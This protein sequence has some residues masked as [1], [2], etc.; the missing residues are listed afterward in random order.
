MEPMGVHLTPEEV[1]VAED[2]VEALLNLNYLIGEDAANP[3][4]IREYTQI[5]DGRLKAMIE[6]LGSAK[7]WNAAEH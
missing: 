2:I 1:R 5:S 7:R 3:N 4:K 6:L